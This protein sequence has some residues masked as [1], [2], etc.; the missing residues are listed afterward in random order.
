M[1]GQYSKR[2]EKQIHPLRSA[3]ARNN[4]PG[5]KKDALAGFLVD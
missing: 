3:Q 2:K 4:K 5:R 1:T